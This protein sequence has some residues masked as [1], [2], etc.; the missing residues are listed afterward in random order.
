MPSLMCCLGGYERL[1]WENNQMGDQSC[2][3]VS[4][5]MLIKFPSEDVKDQVES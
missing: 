4:F 5:K 1:R 3:H 2:I